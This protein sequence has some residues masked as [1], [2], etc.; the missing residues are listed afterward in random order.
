[1][2]N[3]KIE[4]I[5]FILLHRPKISNIMGGENKLTVYKA[6]N[7]AFVYY[8]ATYKHSSSVCNDSSP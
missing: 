7:Y 4:K 8:K 1:M 6:T 2:M 3:K 5:W